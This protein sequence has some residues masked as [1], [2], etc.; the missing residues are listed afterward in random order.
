[1][2]LNDNTTVADEVTVAAIQLDIYKRC[3][4]IKEVVEIISLKIS[5]WGV[6]V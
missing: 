3:C 6:D 2:W 5:F 1:M 4:P